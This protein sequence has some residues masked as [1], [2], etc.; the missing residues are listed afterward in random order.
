MLLAAAVSFDGF[1]L[2]TAGGLTLESGGE[3]DFAISIWSMFTCVKTA[4]LPMVH[5]SCVNNLQ[6]SP[7]DSK[8]F[9]CSDD[10]NIIVWNIEG[11]NVL[12]M[13]CC[14][15]IPRTLQLSPNGKVIFSGYRAPDQYGK[16]AAHDADTGVLLWQT[17]RA[18]LYQVCE[19]VLSP[20]SSLLVSGGGP[21]TDHNSMDNSLSIWNASSG[22]QVLTIE[23][24]HKD[25]IVAL[26]MSPDGQSFYS[27]GGDRSISAWGTVGGNKLWTTDQ[28]HEGAIDSLAVSPNGCTLFSGSRDKDINVWDSSSGTKIRAHVGA[29]KQSVQQL[30]VHVKDAISALVFSPDGSKLVSVGMD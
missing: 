16:L 17:N 8:L 10:K 3:G 14:D 11:L 5:T 19:I 6:V 25:Y 9:S 26:Q 23:N 13:V 4:V 24:A 15:Q 7:C 18:H 12:L 1:K 27:A 2:F 20:D 28:A 22:E 21:Q 29:H 30:N